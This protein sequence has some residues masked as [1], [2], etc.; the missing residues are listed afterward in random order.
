MDPS[1][2][3]GYSSG[4]LDKVFMQDYVTTATFTIGTNLNGSPDPSD[5]TKTIYP[6]GIGAAYNVIPD[7]RTPKME[8]G[9]SVNLAWQTGLSFDVTF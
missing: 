8:L 1:T 9:L 7:L 3:T 5:P 2:G 4:T 6:H